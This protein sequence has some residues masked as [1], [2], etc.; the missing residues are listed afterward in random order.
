MLWWT[1][2]RSLTHWRE[3]WYRAVSQLTILIHL[4]LK[5][6]PQAPSESSFLRTVSVADLIRSSTK[7]F[8][9]W[10]P[11]TEN[12]VQPMSTLVVGT[13][14]LGENMCLRSSLLDIPVPTEIV[15]PAV[16]L[17]ALQ[18]EEMVRHASVCPGDPRQVGEVC[19]Y[20]YFFRLSLRIFWH[21]LK[22]FFSGWNC[23]LLI[24]DL[25][26]TDACCSKPPTSS[27]LTLL[28]ASIFRMLFK[29]RPILKQDTTQ[30]LHPNLDLR[31]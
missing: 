23:Q 2:I 31:S 6:V 14:C 27:R 21:S 20:L 16:P 28:C 13:G 25:R 3:C 15:S 7:T 12:D 17:S 11:T 1:C 29:V 30:L 9:E 18:E 4:H 10:I 22:C 24:V 26:V 5:A 19:K 8:N